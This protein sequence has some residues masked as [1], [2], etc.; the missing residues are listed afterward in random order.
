MLVEWEIYHDKELL[1]QVSSKDISYILDTEV[2]LRRVD[3]YDYHIEAT[4]DDR[5]S[6]GPIDYII[7]QD[8]NQDLG[9]FDVL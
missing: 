8:E 6:F 4:E 2:I 7:P 3:G 1:F 5:I 9:D